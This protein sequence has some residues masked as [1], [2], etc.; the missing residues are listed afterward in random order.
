M[1][2][3]DFFEPFNG[4]LGI[5]NQLLYLVLYQ[6]ESNELYKRQTEW[7]VRFADHTIDLGAD[8]IH[9]SD[10]WGARK[11]LFFNPQIWWEIIYPHM[12][13]VVDHVH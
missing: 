5:E 7:V 3:P 2:T 12:K 1:Q 8:M 13:G 4:V 9:I 10:D 6:D 11:N